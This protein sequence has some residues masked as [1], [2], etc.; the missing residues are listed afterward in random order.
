MSDTAQTEVT[1][2]TTPDNPLA[3]IASVTIFHGMQGAISWV[4][5]KG[6]VV[7]GDL[8]EEETRDALYGFQ[9]VRREFGSFYSGF[10]RW[11]RDKHGDF[12]VDEIFGQMQ[13][14]L[15]DAKQYDA[16]ARVPWQ[17]R[18]AA[19]SD[20]HYYVVGKA[21]LKD[22]EREKWLEIAHDEDLSPLELK[23]SI[24]EGKVV[25][26]EETPAGKGSGSGIVTIYAVRMIYM[27]WAR[28]CAS[29]VLAGELK[30]QTAIL[31]E[32]RPILEFADKLRAAI[33]SKQ[34][35]LQA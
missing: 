24:E 2:I 30:E 35:D 31:E 15:N 5:G 7:R 29:P 26:Q 9:G 32:L 10:V 20:E 6:C 4:P 34:A 23:R 21:D 18:N 16:I 1:T 22:P 17:A 19:F 8:T 28:K 14:P 13:L 3:R 11:A 27:Q 12:F 25:H 33:D